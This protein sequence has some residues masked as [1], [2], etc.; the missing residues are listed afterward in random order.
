MSVEL[1]EKP[2]SKAETQ[3]E[4]LTDGFHLLID[5]LKMNDL[6]TIYGVPGIPITDFGRIAQANGIRVLSFRHEQHAGNAA[7][8]AGYIL[9]LIH[10]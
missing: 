2:E 10:I 6:N 9:S 8:V 5:A 3:D 1:K 4:Q 7:A